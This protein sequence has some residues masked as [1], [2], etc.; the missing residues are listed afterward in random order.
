MGL[1]DRMHHRPNELSGGQRQRVAIA[2]ALVNQPQH[3]AGRR[4]DRQPRL[5]PP[6]RRSW[7]SSTS[8]TDAG[9]T[10][11]LVTHEPDIAAH[12]R[13]QVHL[14][15]GRV[16]AG[17]RDRGRP[18]SEAAPIARAPVA[19]PPSSPSSP[20]LQEGSPPGRL[21]GGARRAAGHRGVGSGRGAIQPDTTVEVK[22]KASGEILQL[23]AETGQTGPARRAAG[24]QSIRATRGTRW[25]RPRPISTWPG[26]S[27]PT[28]PARSG[29]PTSCSSP[30]RSPS[31]S[32]SRRCWTTPTRR[33]PSCGRRCRWTTPGSSWR[34]PTSARRSRARSSRRTSSA[35]R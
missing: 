11:V 31:R 23:N 1:G 9:H 28:P 22:S 13:R 30:G 29:G 7:R 35:A 27:W 16:G 32:T 21:P 2:R 3:P 12:A 10:I 20:Q 25:P 19:V 4:A 14:K 6:A 17:F 15:D 33:P 34:T 26:P 5:R 8:S 18:M 24:P